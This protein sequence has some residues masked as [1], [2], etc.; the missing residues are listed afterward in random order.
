MPGRRL[1]LYMENTQVNI[2]LLTFI[3]NHIVTF[4]NTNLLTRTHTNA[5]N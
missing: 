5:C 4:S 1:L 3:P 2:L